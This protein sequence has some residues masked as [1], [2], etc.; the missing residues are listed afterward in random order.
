MAAKADF[1]LLF[2]GITALGKSFAIKV[3]AAKKRQPLETV[4]MSPVLTSYEIIGGYH[5][6]SP[7]FSLD[8]A[9]NRLK[10][11]MN[12]ADDKGAR[13]SWKDIEEALEIIGL[14]KQDAGRKEFLEK[15]LTEKTPQKSQADLI[16][17]LVQFLEGGIADWNGRTAFLCLP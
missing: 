3:V 11:I 12:T 17:S 8:D 16:I 4:G 10:L 5:P 15:L 14:Q 1:A 13:H 6:K 9:V 7:R 2:E